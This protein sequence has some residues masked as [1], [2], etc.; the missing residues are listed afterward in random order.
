MKIK[1]LDETALENY[2]EIRDLA[3]KYKKLEESLRDD[4]FEILKSENPEAKF[5]NGILKLKKDVGSDEVVCAQKITN[6]ITAEFQKELRDDFDKLSAEEQECFSLRYSVNANY[7]KK[8]KGGQIDY[9][10]T[11]KPAKCT[12]E[13]S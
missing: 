8:G 3:K 7:K 4:I 12:I 5:E 1:T 9:Y 6:S 11:S 10:V 2:K 13:I